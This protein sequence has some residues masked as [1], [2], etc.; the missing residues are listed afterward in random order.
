MFCKSINSITAIIPFSGYGIV[1]IDGISWCYNGD[2]VVIKTVTD[3]LPAETHP[4]Y[5]L[6][7]TRLIL[8]PEVSNI[9]IYQL[10][11]QES[12]SKPITMLFMYIRFFLLCILLLTLDLIYLLSLLS[13]CLTVWE[14]YAF[15]W[16]FRHQICLRHCF[17][18][19]QASMQ[20]NDLVFFRT[21]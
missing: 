4:I 19:C 9:I 7:S 16:I 18:I 15:V 17:V 13:T 2:Q 5:H 20:G 11:N 6:K 21:M 8:E 12:W 10:L 3:V 1:I 14:G